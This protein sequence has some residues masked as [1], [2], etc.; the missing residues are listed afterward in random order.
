LS[1]WNKTQE[2]KWKDSIEEKTTKKERRKIRKD[3]A[4]F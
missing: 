2:R 1:N 3:H 4:E